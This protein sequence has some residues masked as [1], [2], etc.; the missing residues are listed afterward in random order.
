MRKKSTVIAIAALLTVLTSTEL[1]ISNLTVEVEEIEVYPKGLPVEFDGL[2]ILLI[3]DVHGRFSLRKDRILQLAAA[4]KPGIIAYTG[5]AV[6]DSRDDVAAEAAFVAALCEIAPVYYVPGNHEYAAMSDRRL[7]R[8]FENA[9]A[10]VL[11][12]EAAVISRGGAQLVLVGADDANGYDGMQP[13]EQALAGAIPE[14]GE[15]L[16]L[17]CHR[18]DRA[19]EAAELGFSLMLAGHAHGGLVRMPF[20][21]GLIGPGRVLFPRNT[22]GYYNIDG[23]ELVVSRG[24]GNTAGVPRFA[25]RFHM[26]V[27]TLRSGE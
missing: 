1:A 18:Y 10:V 26:P 22:N 4:A 15:C 8:A 16:V 3:S 7:F 2:R 19:E 21:D 13:F 6:N 5:D 24:L 27:I 14:D 12:D 9:G 23:M 20:T 11:R 25:N 17:L